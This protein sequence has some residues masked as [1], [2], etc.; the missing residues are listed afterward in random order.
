M[1]AVLLP[2]GRTLLR[3]V[4]CHARRSTGV[5]QR[6]LHASSTL[7]ARRKGGGRGVAAAQ[8]SAPTS[9]VF[10]GPGSLAEEVGRVWTAWAASPVDD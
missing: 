1:P 2:G 8:P 4:L 5:Q 7:Q 6:A 10:D 3:A 9:A